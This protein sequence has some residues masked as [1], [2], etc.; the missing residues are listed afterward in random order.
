[1][2]DATE[3]A[4]TSPDGLLTD[5]IEMFCAA[6][7]LIQFNRNRHGPLAADIHLSQPIYYLLG[8]SIEVALKAF[9]L[10][11]GES[12]EDLKG[13]YGHDLSKA[14]YNVISRRS[15]PVS[16]I[17]EN[18][19]SIIKLLNPYYSAKEFEYRIT[20]F[21]RLPRSENLMSFLSNIL[22]AIN[23]LLPPRRYKRIIKKIFRDD[24]SFLISSPPRS[25]S[26]D[27]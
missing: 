1:M 23:E 13:K 18:N 15:N 21:K 8:H 5:A 14:A 10:H 24:F 20:G 26:G 22:P 3:D 2:N 25:R 7:I 19:L 17:V 6:G 16:M 9:L 12:L 27:D 4:R 11:S